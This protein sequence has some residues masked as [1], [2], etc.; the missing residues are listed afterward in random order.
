MDQERLPIF[1]A[2][3]NFHKKEP[4]YFCIP[5]HRFDKGVPSV[6]LERFGNEIF[7][8]DLTEADGLDDLHC[9]KEAIKEAAELAAKL[10]KADRTWFTV[11]GT[12]SAVIA[13]IMA[14][15]GSNE[16]IIIARNAHKSAMTGL[17]LSGAMPVWVDPEYDEEWEIAGAVSPKSIEEALFNNP[18][19]KAVL[20]VSPTYYGSVSDI[21]E[22][23]RICHKYNVPLLVD[24]AH[25][26]H[27]SFSQELPPSAL[28]SGADLVAQSIHKTAGAMTQCSLLHYRHFEETNVD[29]ERVDA[30]L[31]MVMSTSPSYILMAS[32]DSAR[33][34]LAM[35]GQ[36]MA[37]DAIELA[38]NL[39]HNL[40]EI[41]GVR[42]YGGFDKEELKRNRIDA[43]RVVFSAR[44]VGISGIRLKEMLFT[45]GEVSLEMADE[46]NVAAVVTYA[47]DMQDVLKLSLA[48]WQCVGGA[49]DASPL[50]K[51]VP[52]VLAPRILLTPR[53]AYFKESEITNLDEAEGKISAISIAPYPPGIPLINPGEIITKEVILKLKQCESFG[54]PL[55]GVSDIKNIKT[56]K[57]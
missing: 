46:K 30:A 20:I 10:F 50:E 28:A 4:A 31:K 38:M 11:N 27:L 56:V 35:N 39:R 44:E 25:G 5:G 53:E 2:I 23:S 15:A 52:P 3:E 22:I 32:I 21:T 55:H 17:I 26:T 29:S 1:E 7:K 41:P 24:E 37:D 36:G 34:Q 54:I 48:L 33:Y 19:A 43:T 42:V 40:A 51:G 45:G 49:S 13:M 14:V 18:D 6:M 16:K 57:L 9:P 47:N 12:T 8:Y